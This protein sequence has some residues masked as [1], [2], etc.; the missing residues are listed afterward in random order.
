MKLF[1]YNHDEGYPSLILETARTD[2]LLHMINVFENGE[3]GLKIS[4]NPCSEP[5]L[6]MHLQAANESKV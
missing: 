5:H 3:L 1:P 6:S 4:I 2:Q